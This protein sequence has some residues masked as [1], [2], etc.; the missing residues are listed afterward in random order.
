MKVTLQREQN[1]DCHGD[2][3]LL[4]TGGDCGCR[5]Y[6]TKGNAGYS[7]APRDCAACPVKQG[8]KKTFELVEV[9]DG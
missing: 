7:Y 4:W 3:E 6:I 8:E 5:A 2:C 1:G 9:P